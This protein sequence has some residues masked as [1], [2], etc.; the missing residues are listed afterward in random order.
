MYRF[1]KIIFVWLLLSS[2]TLS[3]ENSWTG[4][5]HVSWKN[6]TFK[7]NIIQKGDETCHDD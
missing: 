6:G 2:L 5:W 3:A 4:K 7:L 1:F